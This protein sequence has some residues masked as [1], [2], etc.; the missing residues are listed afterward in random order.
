VGNDVE[1][2][3]L[4]EEKVATVEEPDENSWA[5]VVEMLLART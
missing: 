4:E 1:A 5:E 3:E 2:L